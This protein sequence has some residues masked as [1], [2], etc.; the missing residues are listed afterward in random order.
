MCS[1]KGP[2]PSEERNVY[3]WFQ[4]CDAVPDESHVIDGIGVS[5]FVLSLYFTS[6]E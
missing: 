3:H 6:S 5:N 2:H 4:M 1:L